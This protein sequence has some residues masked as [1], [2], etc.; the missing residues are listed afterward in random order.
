MSSPKLAA[1]HLSKIAGNVT[2]RSFSSSPKPAVAAT[3]DV[4]RLGVVGAGQ[5]VS[6]MTL[7]DSYG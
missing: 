7:I 2:R 4:K 5:M 3:A 1:H 6:F